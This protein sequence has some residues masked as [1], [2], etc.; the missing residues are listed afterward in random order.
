MTKDEVKNIF[1][2]TLGIDANTDFESLSY[3]DNEKWDSTSHMNLVAALEDTCDI[4]LDTE[5][6]IDMSSFNKSIEILEKY[7]VSFS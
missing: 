6:I 7:G 5:D 3:A 1:V 4:M 2:S